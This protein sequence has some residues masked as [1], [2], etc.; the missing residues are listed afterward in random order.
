MHAYMH[1]YI[2]VHIDI[3]IHMYHLSNHTVLLYLHIYNTLIYLLTYILVFIVS[4]MRIEFHDMKL[5]IIQR[6]VNQADIVIPNDNDIDA[7]SNSNSNKQHD[8]DRIN[9]R[10]NSIVYELNFSDTMLSCDASCDAINELQVISCH[11]S[12]GTMNISIQHQYIQ[13]SLMNHH[14]H[15]LSECY[16]LHHHTTHAV[17]SNS[18]HT[19]T[20]TTIVH[21]DR[22]Y[23]N[24]SV[25]ASICHIKPWSL[26][27][28]STGILYAAIESQSQYAD[29]RTSSSSYAKACH[30]TMN[31]RIPSIEIDTC[32]TE[33]YM[34][35][36]AIKEII[37][38]KAKDRIKNKNKKL[39]VTVSSIPSTSS[40]ALKSSMPLQVHMWMN[41]IEC[42]AMINTHRHRHGNS[43]SHAASDP[44]NSTNHTATPTAAAA[45]ALHTLELIWNNMKYNG[46]LYRS[47]QSSKNIISHHSTLICDSIDLNLLVNQMHNHIQEYNILNLPAIS[48]DIGVGIN[49]EH[50]HDMGMDTHYAHITK[51]LPYSS[52]KHHVYMSVDSIG[53]AF[54]AALLDT[55]YIYLMQKV[56][57]TDSNNSSGNMSIAGTDGSLNGMMNSNTSIRCNGYY[58]TNMIFLPHRGGLM[59]F[60]LCLIR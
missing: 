34:V 20:A 17:N 23:M 36:N 29:S 42:K 49:H 53:T 7:N 46:V 40:V 13:T 25:S 19:T 38:L 3:H 21:N 37:P 2:H 56:S 55:I 24:S 1:A 14:N 44:V 12:C 47:I 35:Y 10:H 4:H 43:N 11:L 15:H 57:F 60:Y 45:A 22:R 16:K 28:T 41:V 27:C 31:L 39:H 51:I 54:T 30:I 9:N 59:I 33:V 18:T 48:I 8:N 50:E 26:E 5:C 52:N 58:N 6:D 32:M